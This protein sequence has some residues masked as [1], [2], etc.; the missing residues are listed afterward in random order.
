MSKFFTSFLLQNIVS[1]ILVVLHHLKKDSLVFVKKLAQ[2]KSL[3]FGT[4]DLLNF[5]CLTHSALEMLGCKTMIKHTDA[6][7]EF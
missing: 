5:H 3:L 2:N 6:L 7:N 1:K 4:F